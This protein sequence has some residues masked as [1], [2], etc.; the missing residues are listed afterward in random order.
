MSSGRL[1]QTSAT[2]A[3][4]R[5]AHGRVFR[6]DSVDHLSHTDW[7]ASA[8]VGVLTIVY[9]RNDDEVGDDLALRS[10]EI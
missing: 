7:P 3:A 6:A 5:T 8:A 10:P 4:E 9:L 1:L 2:S